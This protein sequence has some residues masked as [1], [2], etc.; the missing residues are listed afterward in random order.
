MIGSCFYSGQGLGNQLWAYSVI[1]SIAED[2][3]FSFGF[4]G[5]KRFKGEVLFPNLKFGDPI[6]ANPPSVPREWV[7][8]GFKHYYREEIVRNSN[9]IDVSLFDPKIWSVADGTFLDGGFQSEKY[10]S[11]PY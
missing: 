2:R 8:T 1:R 9:G 11:N 6:E 5:Q 7:P 10:F 4:L 3:E